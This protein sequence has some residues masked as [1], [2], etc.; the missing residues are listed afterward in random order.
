[1]NMH[2]DTLSYANDLE[3]AGVVR[4]HAEAIAK[5]QAKAIGDLVEHDLVT[6]DFHRTESA[7]TRAE[8]KQELAALRAEF[9]QELA[10]LRAEFKQELAVNKAELQNEIRKEVHTL[11]LEIRQDIDALRLQIRS[12]QYGSAIAAFVVSAAVLLSRLIK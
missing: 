1:M 7:L 3:K 11:R 5:L 9:K 6:R 2:V 8:F 10:A 12:L 4:A